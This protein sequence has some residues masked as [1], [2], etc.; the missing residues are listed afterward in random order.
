MLQVDPNSVE[1]K[2]AL[3]RLNKCIEKKNLDA[4][5][6][7][8]QKRDLKEEDIVVGVGNHLISK[9]AGRTLTNK[10]KSQL[11]CP[12]GCSAKL[13][14][15]EKTYIGTL[16]LYFMHCIYVPTMKMAGALSVH[17][18]VCLSICMSHHQQ[19]PLSKSNS[20]DQSVKKLGLI[21]KYHHVFFK[22][23]NI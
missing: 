19:H 11:N 23:D 9:L 5:W 7:I 20:F 14:Y 8:Q 12:C 1:F 21:V 13:E 15:G 3:R 22:I 4:L 6:T 17:L 16:D 2:Q 18:F 10:A